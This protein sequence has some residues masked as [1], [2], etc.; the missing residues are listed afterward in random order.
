MCT[1][2][3]TDRLNFRYDSGG[4]FTGNTIPA[5]EV[6]ICPVTVNL[7]LSPPSAVG[8]NVYS[9]SGV[10]DCDVIALDSNGQTVWSPSVTKP[11]AATGTYWLS[12]TGSGAPSNAVY[13]NVICG[14]T[15]GSGISGYISYQ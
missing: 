3:G 15:T 13:Y 12:T 7:S 2:Y 14:M 8:I 10:N 5:W 6:F 1:G 4:I 9:T 11:G